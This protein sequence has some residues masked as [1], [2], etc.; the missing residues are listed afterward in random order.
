MLESGDLHVT[1]RAV[2]LAGNTSEPAR[3]VVHVTQGTRVRYDEDFHQEKRLGNHHL[4]D[5]KGLTMLVVMLLGAATL[6]GGVMYLDRRRRRRWVVVPTEIDDVSLAVAEAAIKFLRRRHIIE[7]AIASA[8]TAVGFPSP[9][10]LGLVPGIFA[11]GYAGQ[12]IADTVALRNAR[13]DSN[14]DHAR[15]DADLPVRPVGT[16]AD[17]VPAAVF[18]AAQRAALPTA[19]VEPRRN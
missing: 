11:M 9:A 6:G 7:A 2:D 18:A 5:T 3:L 19:S 8:L 1:A 13:S 15:G 4:F 16:L 10:W 12:L 17:R 14:D